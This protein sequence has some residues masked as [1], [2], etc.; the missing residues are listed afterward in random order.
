[1][2]P[3]IQALNLGST[4]FLPWA[5]SLTSLSLVLLICKMRIWEDP[6]NRVT[7]MCRR[8]GECVAQKAPEHGGSRA[9]PV[10]LCSAPGTVMWNAV[11]HFPSSTG[12]KRSSLHSREERDITKN[13]EPGGSGVERGGGG[14][15]L[16]QG[17]LQGSQTEPR[18]G[19]RAWGCLPTGLKDD[20]F[21]LLKMKKDRNKSPKRQMGKAT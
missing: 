8:V 6:L 19:Q 4:P 10:P 3:K 17:Q 18:G 21:P 11:Y 15:D 7:E 2:N 12:W 16:A 20:S 14:G 13:N 1:M 9:F 5:N